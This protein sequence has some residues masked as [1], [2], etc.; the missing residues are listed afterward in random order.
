MDSVYNWLKLRLPDEVFIHFTTNYPELMKL[1]FFE[2]QGE[3]DLMEIASNCVIELILLA[4]KR[5]EY[6]GIRIYIVDNIEG[7]QA[8]VK[9]AVDDGDPDVG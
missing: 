2:L 9:E 6:E 3:Y 7:L 8:K 5:K 1:I 4:K